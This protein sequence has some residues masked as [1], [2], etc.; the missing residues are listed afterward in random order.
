MLST[1]GKGSEAYDFKLKDSSGRVVNLSDFKGKIVFI[2]I[3]A[4]PCTG[5]LKFKRD[6]ENAVY[7]VFRIIGDFVVISINVDAQREKWLKGI[8]K[9]S[10][11]GFVNLSTEKF[12]GHPLID[13]YRIAA[14]PTLLLIDREGKIISATLPYAASSKAL[15]KIIRESLAHKNDTNGLSEY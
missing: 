12:A 6:F 9:Y 7:P 10:N 2:D 8:P 11:P 1:F 3:W 5:C 14:V 15:I 4:N 13:K